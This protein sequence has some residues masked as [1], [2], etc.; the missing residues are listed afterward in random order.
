MPHECK[1]G[2]TVKTSSGRQGHVR[3]TVDDAHG[4]KGEL[5]DGESI[6]SMFTEVNNSD[7]N[8]D[9]SGTGD[10]DG[11]STTNSDSTVSDSTDMDASTG[12][13]ASIIAFMNKPL[14]DIED[15]D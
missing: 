6:E 1:C 15:N 9:N 2:K 8:T 11:T 4:D 13:I 14:V 5:P 10:S 12:V 7:D 3:F